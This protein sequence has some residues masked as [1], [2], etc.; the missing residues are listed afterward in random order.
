MSGIIVDEVSKQYSGTRVIDE[1]DLDV[2]DGE[3][4]ALLGP[5]G[6]GK[7][8]TLRIIAGLEQPDAGTVRVGDRVVDDPANGV[9]IPAHRRDIGMVFQSYALWPH[10]SVAGNVGYPLRA[11]R[12]RGPSVRSA[13]GNALE[14][15]GLGGFEKRSIASL[16]GGQQQRVALARALVSDPSALLL[17]E[18]L[19]N[20]DAGLR[21]SLRAE[22]RRIAREQPRTTVYV[23]HDQTEA[24][25]LADRI[26]VIFGGRVAQSGAPKEIWAA[27]VDDRVA[28][29]VGYDNIVPAAVT[30]THN[31]SVTL[32]IP[33]HGA[34]PVEVH[35]RRGARELYGAS[36]ALAFRSS[37]V[38]IRQT[39]SESVDGGLVAVVQDVTELADHVEFLLSWAN[40]TVRAEI[41]IDQLAQIPHPGQCV[42][43]EIDST[44]A[45]A[46]A[47]A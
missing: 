19:S 3:F 17:D 1:V 2:A 35:A 41:P 15:V 33:G 16:S 36:V 4:V 9:H 23:T 47:T 5:S 11:R 43:L 18:P 42:R 12:R 38:R 32:S 8:T 7:T 40:T 45:V 39:Q 22:F 24:L 34:E 21:S 26:L 28:G 14:L 37:G 31:E 13:V 25:T 10:L 46:V 30:R 29:F 27:P 44:R 20:L 6:C